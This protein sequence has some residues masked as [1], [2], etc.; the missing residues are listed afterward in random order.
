M[1]NTLNHYDFVPEIVPRIMSGKLTYKICIKKEHI[2]T[3]GTCALYLSV[4]HIGKRKKLP[5][6]ISVK[7]MHFDE[8]RQ[9]VKKICKNANDYNLLIEKMLA[10]LNKIEI[11]FRLN[12]EQIT[13][14]KVI[15][16]LLNPT[17]RICFNAFADRY[18]EYEK[19]KQI[20]MPSTYRQQKSALSKIKAY[21]NPILFNEI[22]FQFIKEFRAYMKSTLKNKPATIE[23]TIK[24]FKKF[25]VAAGESGVSLKMKST[26]I[27]VSEMK[28]DFTF[29]TPKEINALYHFYNQTY[30]NKTWK[31]ILKRY[32]FSCFTGLRISD[33]E[34]IGPD[35]FFDDILVFN[36]QKGGKLI[37]LKLNETARSLIE[38]PEIFNGDYT[39]EYINRELK[40]IAKA[41]GIKKRLY[42]HSSR[43]TFATNYLMC[44]GN[45]VI[46][47]QE[48]LQHSKIETTMIYVHVVRKIKD[49]GLDRMD[50]IIKNSQ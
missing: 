6:N 21:K 46:E 26:K 27:K 44:A 4:Y 40:L 33:I 28:G 13:V 23:G 5:L 7:T 43:H 11:N 10:A 17:V 29:L 24:N 2:R 47:L 9:R 22:D 15:E 35:N 30:T 39:R 45:T 36:A 25:Y 32:L 37:R 1:H 8:K 18:L 49:K 34:T 20:I 38:L 14:E 19:E 16:D 31:N 50:S 41:C 12:N 42:Y 3:D 48:I